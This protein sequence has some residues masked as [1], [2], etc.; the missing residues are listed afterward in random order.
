MAKRIKGDD[1]WIPLADLMTGLMLIFLLIAAAAIRNSH[2]TASDY[3]HKKQDIYKSLKM[4]FSEKELHDW[5][6]EII[7]SPTLSVRFKNPEVLFASGKSDLQPKFE[8]ILAQFFPRYLKV[9]SNKDYES[10]V[11]HMQIEGYTSS[12]WIGAGDI[13]DAFFNN[14]NLSQ[15]RT[16]STLK[17]LYYLDQSTESNLQ[18][19][20]GWSTESYHKYLRN[21]VTANGLSSSHLIYKDNCDIEKNSNCVEDKQRSQRVEFTIIFNSDQIAN[22][23]AG[24][25]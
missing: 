17:Y 21:E 18:Q 12:L 24:A 14:M 1:Y 23:L 9:V 3:V 13:N 25:N 7:E 8:I 22:S 4:E 2:E 11:S 6:A 15:Q 10:M 5:G 20:L 16:I 19:E